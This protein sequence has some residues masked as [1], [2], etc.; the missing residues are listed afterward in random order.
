MKQHVRVL[1]VDNSATVRQT[2]SSIL[3]ADPDIEVIGTAAD[4]YAAR[5]RSRARLRT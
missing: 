5:T 2:L 4:P 3:S 1:I